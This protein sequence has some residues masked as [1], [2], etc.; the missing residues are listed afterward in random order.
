MMRTILRNPLLA[1]LV[2]GVMIGV[3]SD[4][5]AA[6]VGERAPSFSLPSLGGGSVS[7][8]SLRG[9]VV[10]IDFWASWCEPCK[11][12]MP[13]LERLY[14]R[15]KGKGVELI[16]INIDKDRA[17]AARFLSGVRTSFP[18][19][20]DPSSGVAGQYDPP[21]MPSSY[22]VDKRG[23]IRYVNS[24]FEPGDEAKFARELDDLLSK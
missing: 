2:L 19:L 24:G 11:K 23:L 20:L 9:K 5:R 4:A 14:Q 18:T 22:V 1:A 12:E 8:S 7:L 3:V 15:Y 21:K 17:N 6:A 10:F 13:I 16:A